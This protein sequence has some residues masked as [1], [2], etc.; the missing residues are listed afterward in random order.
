[1]AK[2]IEGR[3]NPMKVDPYLLVTELGQMPKRPR[4]YT[5]PKRGSSRILKKKE[6][7]GN[8]YLSFG[9]IQSAG[10]R[11]KGVFPGVAGGEGVGTGQ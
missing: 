11:E 8:L 2:G 3:S 7:S 9:D 1:M 5:S 6:R 4:E 10:N